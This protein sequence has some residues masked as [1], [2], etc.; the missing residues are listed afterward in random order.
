MGLV[1]QGIILGF[2]IV[3]PGMSGGTVFLIFGFYEQMVKDLLRLRLRPYLP[4]AGGILLGI[5]GGGFTFAFFFENHRDPTV[6]FLLGC[7]LASIKAVLRDCCPKG[8]KNRFTM[9]FLGALIGFFLVAEPLGS[10]IET[11][12]ASWWLLMIGGAFSSAAMII[13]GIP[14]SSVLILLGLYD[15]MLFSI[16]DLQIWNLLFFGVGSLL[17]IFLLLN[18]LGKL[19]EQYRAQVSYFFAGLI[20]GS[21]RAI[22]PSGANPLVVFLFAA[23]FLLVWIWIGKESPQIL[24]GES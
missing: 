5:F 19:Y 8:C 9:M 7:L 13:P 4:L 12:N 20:L 17:G 15:T 22:M 23:G 18:L 6:A 2:I 16:K 3:L 14:G 1:I 10:G 24:G 11:E 21:S